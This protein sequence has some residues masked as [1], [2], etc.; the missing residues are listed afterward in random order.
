[1]RR[2]SPPTTGLPSHEDLP[3]EPV[4]RRPSAFRRRLL[5]VLAVVVPLVAWLSVA[6]GARGPA[7]AED[8]PVRSTTVLSETYTVDQKYRSMTGPYSQQPLRLATGTAVED[9]GV[10]ELLWIVGYRAVMVAADGV[11]PQ[12]PEFMCHSNLDIDVSAHRETLGANPSFSSRLFTLSQGQQTVRF[13][14]GF[15]IPVLSDEVLSLTTQVLNLNHEGEV[16]D[17]RHQ[18]TVEYVRDSDLE[19]RLTPLFP[20]GAYGLRLLEGDSAYFGVAD[21][22]PEQHGP[23]C[24]VGESASDHAYE[25]GLGRTFTGHWVV[26]PGRE[27]NRTLVTHLMQ[28]PFD[29]TV[30]YIAVHLHPFA[31]SLELWDRTTDTLVFRSEAEGIEGRIGLESVTA[32][33]SEEGVA[34]FADHEYEMVS[35]Y[36]N[37]SDEPQDSMAVMYIY[38]RDTDMETRLRGWR[39]TKDR[40]ELGSAAR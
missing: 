27:V 9:E 30:H 1:M 25:D 16:F 24:L 32:F 18:I 3:H 39:P 20:I 10:P 17:V 22:D 12:K 13:P 40:R 5:A 36:D 35:V 28:I 11:T 8:P 33:S 23:G 15:G 21:P 6:R 34:V 31:E 4:D 7:R 2:M 19:R 26:P 37:L 38:L 29:T 14:D